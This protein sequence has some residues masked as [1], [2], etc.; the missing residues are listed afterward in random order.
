[1]HCTGAQFYARVLKFVWLV[2][3]SNLDLVLFLVSFAST[4]KREYDR[5]IIVI[6]ACVSGESHAAI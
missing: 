3:I 6:I 1:V 2:T 5:K 4:G